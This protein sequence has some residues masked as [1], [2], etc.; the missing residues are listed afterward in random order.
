MI[1]VRCLLAAILVFSFFF[2][3]KTAY[4]M[5][6]SDWSSDVCS[7]DLVPGIVFH[8]AHLGGG[9]ERIRNPLGSAF[10]VGREGDADMAIVKNGI[11][12]SIGLLD[13]VEALGDEEGLD[14]IASHAAACAVKEIAPHELR[15]FLE[16]KP[17][18]MRTD[19]RVDLPGQPP[20]GL[21][22]RRTSRGWGRAE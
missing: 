8:R 13:L 15:N 19:C 7:S 2:K 5:R 16:H 6:I 22:E 1:G 14:P 3:Q 4:E 18:P 17:Q 10:I 9:A 11:V 20:G 21:V 12:L